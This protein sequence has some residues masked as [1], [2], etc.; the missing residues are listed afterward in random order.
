MGNIYT[1]YDLAGASKGRG[2]TRSA[3]EKKATKKA[4]RTKVKLLRFT[5][6]FMA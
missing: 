1:V 3:K 4:A 6:D 5:G 2:A